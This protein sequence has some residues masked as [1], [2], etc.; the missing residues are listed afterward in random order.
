MKTALKDSN[1]R[2]SKTFLREVPSKDS[3][4]ENS[5]YEVHQMKILKTKNIK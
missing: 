2:V 4:F 5:K 3:E 1:S